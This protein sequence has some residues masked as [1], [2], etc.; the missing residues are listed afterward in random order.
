VLL[1]L[2]VV[3]VLFGVFPVA[4]LA[5]LLVGLVMKVWLRFARRGAVPAA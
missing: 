1:V 4:G 3:G 2:G 5:A